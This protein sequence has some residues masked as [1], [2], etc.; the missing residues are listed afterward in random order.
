MIGAV[1]TLNTREW[2]KVAKRLKKQK[3]SSEDIMMVEGLLSTSNAWESLKE[4][5]GRDKRYDEFN[6]KHRVSEKLFDAQ[7][8]SAA[9]HVAYTVI[10]MLDEL[11]E[12]N[13]EG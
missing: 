2:D 10:R 13:N 6:D 8:C 12:V 11:E 1:V 7:C 4:I 5:L 3:V 9:I